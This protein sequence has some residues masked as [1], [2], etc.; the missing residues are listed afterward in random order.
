MWAGAQYAA[1]TAAPNEPGA[2][3]NRQHC[4]LLLFGCLFELAEE[5]H[6]QA[7]LRKQQKGGMA[8]R[9]PHCDCVGVCSSGVGFSGDYSEYF[10]LQV[11]EDSL[12]YL[13][14][15]NHILHTLYPDCITVAEVQTHSLAPPT[16][17]APTSAFALYSALVMCETLCLWNARWCYHSGT[18]SFL[19]ASVAYESFC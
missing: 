13:M 5:T 14:M 12:V 15:A 1:E 17:Y 10:G 2:S 3:R 16:F 19:K 4:G 7:N 9:M 18:V 11:D 6:S 8:F